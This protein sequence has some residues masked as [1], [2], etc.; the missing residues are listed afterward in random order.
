MVDEQRVLLHWYAGQALLHLPPDSNKWD[1][2]RRAADLA[3][4]VLEEVEKRCKK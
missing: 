2:A 1:T 4:A 3:E